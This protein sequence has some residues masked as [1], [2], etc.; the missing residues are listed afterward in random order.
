MK[1]APKKV[2]HPVI[3]LDIHSAFGLVTCHIVMEEQVHAPLL[4]AMFVKIAKNLNQEVLDAILVFVSV[5]ELKNTK[6]SSDIARSI[7]MP[8]IDRL[9]TLLGTGPHLSK[10]QL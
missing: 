6:L 2:R 10:L 4:I 3:L 9:I 7:E 5:H 1:L 8:V